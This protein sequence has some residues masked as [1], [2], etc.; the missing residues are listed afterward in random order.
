MVSLSQQTTLASKAKVSQYTMCSIIV[1]VMRCLTEFQEFITYVHQSNIGLGSK[2][3]AV[4]GGSINNR[5]WGEQ[6]H[7]DALEW[8][9]IFPQWISD[10][11]QLNWYMYDGWADGGSH[12]K[13]QSCL[14][15][16]GGI[17]IG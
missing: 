7:W 17:W 8:Q 10:W 16:A 5:M 3:S 15:R 13:A 2:H 9:H 12:N 6:V 11:K 4:S 14:G 1:Y